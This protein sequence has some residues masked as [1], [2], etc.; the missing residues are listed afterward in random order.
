LFK[1]SGITGKENMDE[2]KQKRLTETVKGA[3]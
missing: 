3:G 1:V 2:Q